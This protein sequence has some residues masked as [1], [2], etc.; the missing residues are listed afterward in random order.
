MHEEQSR[1]FRQHVA[2][3]RGHLDPI[4]PQ[5]L[6]DRVDFVPKQNEI[7]RDGGLATSGRLKIYCG[8]DAQ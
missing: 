8:S 1:L 2:M 3:E 7:S 4:F 5:R 6:D